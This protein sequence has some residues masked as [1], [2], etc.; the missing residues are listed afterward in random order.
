MYNSAIIILDHC[1]VQVAILFLSAVAGADHGMA[2]GISPAIHHH[3]AAY[4]G[5]G[6]GT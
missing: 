3:T 5:G 2:A 6:S 4:T 1:E